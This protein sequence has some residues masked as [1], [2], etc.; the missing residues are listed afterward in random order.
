MEISELDADTAGD[1]D[2]MYRRIRISRDY[3]NI[4]K[5]RVLMHEWMHA[6]MYT[7][8]VGSVIPDEVEEIIAQSVEHALEEFLRQIAPQLFEEKEST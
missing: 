2:G 1:T 5:W 6:V 3:D 4:R 7:N 8:G